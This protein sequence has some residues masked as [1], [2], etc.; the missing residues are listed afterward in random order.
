MN[1]ARSLLAPLRLH[2]ALA[3]AALLLAAVCGLA[4]RS[5]GAIDDVLRTVDR[6]AFAQAELID[7]D[8]SLSDI[9][10]VARSYAR[11]QDPVLLAAYERLGPR[12][13]AALDRLDALVPSPGLTRYG[14]DALAALARERQQLAS[15]IV[16]D[17]RSGDLAAARLL[18]QQG[19]GHGA[20]E[21][22]RSTIASLQTEARRVLSLDLKSMARARTVFLVALWVSGAL[23]VLL[24]ALVARTLVRLPG[25]RRRA[26]PP[27]DFVNVREYL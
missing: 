8:Q 6:T 4:S 1:A 13:D 15:D 22:V 11:T 2:I 18:G 17:A 26:P 9:L 23:A 14:V 16:S 20:M 7:I 24:L 21:A 19:D 12:I 3:A 10:D 25:P 5:L 27:S